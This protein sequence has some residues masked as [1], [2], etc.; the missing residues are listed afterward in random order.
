LL[1]LNARR[2]RERIDYL[3]YCTGREEGRYDLASEWRELLARVLHAPV[4]ASSVAGWAAQSAA[5]V[6]A[7]GAAEHGPAAPRRL[8]EF[9]L[10]S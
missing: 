2:G 1:F 9:E 10:L 4:D 8:G 5:E 6:R 3:S 7:D